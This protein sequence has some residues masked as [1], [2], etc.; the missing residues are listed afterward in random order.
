MKLST[1]L[2]CEEYCYTQ[3]QCTIT[4]SPS[5]KRLHSSQCTLSPFL[6]YMPD[7][8]PAIIASIP[9]QYSIP[10]IVGIPIV[11]GVLALAAVPSFAGVPSAACNLDVEG[12]FL[13]PYNL[14]MLIFLPAF[15]VPVV[16]PF[17]GATSVIC[18]RAVVCVRGVVYVRP[19]AGVPAICRPTASGSHCSKRSRCRW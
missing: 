19:V 16:T 4:F 2:L 5:E 14:L 3:A 15:G 7:R 11:A 1:L 10:A 17:S 9:I 8:L 6:F 18:V 13:L 12:A